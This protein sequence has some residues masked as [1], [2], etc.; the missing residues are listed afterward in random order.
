M[1]EIKVQIKGDNEDFKRKMKES[2][3][4][5][6]GFANYVKESLGQIKEGLVDI[7]GDNGFGGLKKLFGEAGIAAGVTLLGGKIV[8]AFKEGGSAAIEFENTVSKLRLSLGVAQAG[9]AG[10]MANWIESISGAMG[11]VEENTAAFNQ[12]IAAKIPVA[13]AQRM[14]IDLQ[15]AARQTGS[16]LGELTHAFTEMKTLGEVP[17]RFFKENLPIAALV[18]NMLGPA[19]PPK[20]GEAA[21]PE[22]ESLAARVQ[23]RGGADWMLRVVLPSI[24]PGGMQSQ[25]RIEAEAT[26]LGQ[27]KDLGVQYEAMTRE[28][29]TILLPTMKDFT[30]WL[31]TEIPVIAE[32]LK[33]FAGALEGVL[34]WIGSF[35]PA[36]TRAE[37]YKGGFMGA[38]IP[39]KA[40]VNY[41]GIWDFL[42][43]GFKEAMTP[44]SQTNQKLDAAADKLN[45][46]LDPK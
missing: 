13:D 29:G 38:E 43:Q 1:A 25:A 17:A 3:E 18:K 24:S 9:M 40:Q 14:L 33:A 4:D 12:L 30:G 5:A 23:A 42:G 6:R 19:P 32:D 44:I 36:F 46:A 22:E 21:K 2:G 15:N 10:D 35:A 11:S 16:D 37:P 26:E 45:R 7:M 41:P 34:K 27:M 31:R 28:I 20:P 39:A 8:D